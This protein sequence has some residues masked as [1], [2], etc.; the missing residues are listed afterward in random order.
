MFSSDNKIFQYGKEGGKEENLI[1]E[2][3]SGDSF[4]KNP[5]YHCS[6][7]LGSSLFH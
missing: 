4:G 6:V 5:A 7:Q 3:M 1:L 2:I